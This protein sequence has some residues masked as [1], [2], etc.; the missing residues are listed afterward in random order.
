MWSLACCF[1]VSAPLDFFIPYFKFVKYLPSSLSYI[2][3]RA[4]YSWLPRFATQ[5]RFNLD[6]DALT[7]VSILNYTWDDKASLTGDTGR[8]IGRKAW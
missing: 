3:C 4:G 8:L 2:A 5:S 7:V 6:S 1:F